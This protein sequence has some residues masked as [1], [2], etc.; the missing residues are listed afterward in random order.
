MN[1]RTRSI[2][3]KF[4]IGEVAMGDTTPKD[5]HFWLDGEMMANPLYHSPRFGYRLFRQAYIDRASVPESYVLNHPNRP[6]L[7]DTFH[8][9]RTLGQTH[10]FAVTVVIV[11]SDAR[12]YKDDFEGL[13]LVTEPY[14]T[15]YLTR[16]ARE[17]D[18]DVVDLYDGLKP[19]ATKELLYHRDD[20]H[21]NE[22][23]HS[24]V[25]DILANTLSHGANLVLKH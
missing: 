17:M 10:N 20:T 25:A 14:F 22:R 16:L 13:D 11:P 8:R 21:W 19:Y 12:L 18:F 6:R 7:D 15:R 5:P 9:M 23:G 4:A 1:I 3:R 24:I 2:I